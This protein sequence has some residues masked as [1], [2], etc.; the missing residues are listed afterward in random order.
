MIVY[1]NVYSD[2]HQRKHHSSASL[3]FVWGIHQGLVNSPHKWPVMRKM[4]PFD[5]VIM[6]LARGGGHNPDIETFSKL[7]A[8]CNGNPPIFAGFLSH[9]DVIKW[10]HFPRSWPFVRGIHRWP[11]N[12]PHKASDAELGCFLWST[13]KRLSKQ[14]RGWWFETPLCPS[15]RHRNDHKVPV[16]QSFGVFSVRRLN[17]QS[18]THSSCR[19]FET[20]R[21][22]YN[23]CIML[24]ACREPA[25]DHRLQEVLHVF[26]IKH[27]VFH[28]PALWY[29]D[30]YI[31]I[32]IHY[33]QKIWNI[34]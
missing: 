30:I 7:L 29:F 15:W 23:L 4:F 1:S 16:M 3:A 14:S 18:N 9:D 31:Y 8:L 21:R 10:E 33:R 27:N 24:A 2:A 22:S 32:Y 11:V 12:S 28:I 25:D 20:P 19:W 26:S 34:F 5:D 13:Y 17:K 6:V